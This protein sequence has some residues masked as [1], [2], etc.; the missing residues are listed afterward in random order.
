MVSIRMGSMEEPEAPPPP[1]AP[2]PSE[3]EAA[4]KPGPLP[5]PAGAVQIPDHYRMPFFHG[6][7]ATPTAVPSATERLRNLMLVQKRKRRRG[8]LTGLLAGQVLIIAL[9]LGGL[10]TLHRYPQMKLQ[11]PIGVQAIVFLGMA[12]GAALM[13]GVVGLIFT[14]Q[15]LRAFFG[16]RSTSLFTAFGRGLKRVFLTGAALGVSMGI[17]LGTA[18]FMIPGSEWKPTV[19]Y[20]RSQ[21]RSALDASKAKVKSMFHRH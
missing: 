1:P 16:K 11:A 2:G 18:W 3:P 12:G 14:V 7:M 13:L 21:A 19:D 17:I 5:D 4:P 15:G 9:D 8:F 6:K 10:W 20:T